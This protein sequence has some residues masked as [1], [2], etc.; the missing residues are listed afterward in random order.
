MLNQ[1]LFLPRR[2]GR[3]VE[4]DSLENYCT[5]MVPGVRIPLSPPK[6]FQ[7]WKPFLLFTTYHKVLVI[8][9]EGA[10]HSIKKRDE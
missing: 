8:S 6:G 2:Y 7:K 9:T 3:V 1:L 10:Y 4:C 5:V